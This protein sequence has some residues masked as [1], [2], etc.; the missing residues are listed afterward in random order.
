[1][2]VYLIQEIRFDP[3]YNF[4]KMEVETETRK[5]EYCLC[6]YSVEKRQIMSVG[7]A[8]FVALVIFS[9]G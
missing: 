4:K 8:D 9:I 2:T 7:Q 5:T 3:F 1:M 6:N